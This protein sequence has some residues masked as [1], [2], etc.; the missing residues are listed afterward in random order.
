MIKQDLYLVDKMVDYKKYYAAMQDTY[1][2]ILNEAKFNKLSGWNKRSKQNVEKGLE[3]EI[4]KRFDHVI[5]KLDWKQKKLNN[6]LYGWIVMAVD[7]VR[8]KPLYTIRN[9]LNGK[10]LKVHKG[11]IRKIFSPCFI[12]HFEDNRNDVQRLIDFDRMDKD[13][14]DKLLNDDNFEDQQERKDEDNG[15]IKY[16]DVEKID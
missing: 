1:K 11:K 10:E 8:P 12:Q 13:D 9:I 6:F 16:D 5:F 15:Y 2:V 14:R 4:I 3:S 7:N